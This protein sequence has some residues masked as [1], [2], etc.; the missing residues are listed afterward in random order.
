MIHIWMSH[1]NHSFSHLITYY[2]AHTGSAY[3][4]SLRVTK[5]TKVYTTASHPC[6]MQ[7]V[8]ISVSFHL[9]YKVCDVWRRDWGMKNH[10]AQRAM[11]TP[12]TLFL[13]ITHAHTL[14]LSIP[15]L[16]PSIHS[17]PRHH[18]SLRVLGLNAWRNN[19]STVCYHG[20]SLMAVTLFPYGTEYQLYFSKKCLCYMHQ[21]SSTLSG[22]SL[23]LTLG[24]TIGKELWP[25]CGTGAQ[26][27]PNLMWLK[28]AFRVLIVTAVELAL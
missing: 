26:T 16:P 14:H 24:G 8:Q 20:N 13:S 19:H 28:H 25:I 21:C 5:A 7:K 17:I 22:F 27:I 18:F 2:S 4:F 11:Q 3:D 1:V 23:F 10:F 6:D 12:P 15:F 9:C